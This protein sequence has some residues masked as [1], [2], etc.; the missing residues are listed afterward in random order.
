MRLAAAAPRGGMVPGGAEVFFL[1]ESGS[2]TADRE[3][4][5]K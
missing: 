5:D 4:T 2:G 3:E 1:S